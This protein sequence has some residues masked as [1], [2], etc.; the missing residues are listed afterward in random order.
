MDATADDYY[1]LLLA[2]R[3]RGPAWAED[4]DLLRGVAEELARVHA[5]TLYLLEEADPRSTY[6]MLAAWER[7]AGLPDQ[8]GGGIGSS[9]DERQRRLHQKLTSRG[10]QS[11]AFFIGVAAALGYPGARITEFRPF[12]CVSACEDSLDPDPWRHVW[13]IEFPQS[14]G[15]VEFTALSTCTEALREWGDDM[16]ECVINRLK[17]AHTIVYFAYGV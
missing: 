11:R 17:P 12:T 8:C 2:L 1:R 13:R 6:E 3:P 4:D 14:T 9:I 10:G 5:R 16:V 7:N 15:I